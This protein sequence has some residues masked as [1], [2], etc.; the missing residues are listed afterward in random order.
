MWAFLLKIHAQ[1]IE[2]KCEKLKKEIREL[3]KECQTCQTDEECFLDEKSLI[4][5]PFG[6]Y[7]IRSHAYDD[8]EYLALTEKK[9]EKYNKECPV[10]K[11]DCPPKPKNYEIGCREGKCVDLRF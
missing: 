9:I 5:C 8:G 4:W 7:F 2:K 10:C 11:Y 6:C 3:I 1:N